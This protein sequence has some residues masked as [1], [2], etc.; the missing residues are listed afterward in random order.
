MTTSIET[1]ERQLVQ[2]LERLGD[3]LADDRLVGDLYQAL[4]GCALRPPDGGG[5]LTLSWGRAAELLNAA[6]AA[7]AQPAVEGLEQSG[8]EGEVSQRA[9]DALE[10]ELGWA[11]APRDTGQADDAHSDRPASPP[12]GDHEPPEWERRAHEE[13]EASRLNRPA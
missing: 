3:G 11:L 6:R 9:R 1:L 8:G 4:A 7:R 2:D 10:R 13:A 12:P 5:H